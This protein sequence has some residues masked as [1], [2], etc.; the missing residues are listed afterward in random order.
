MYV[1][2]DGQFRDAEHSP[3]VAVNDRDKV[4][5]SKRCHVLSWS[6]R[7]TASTYAAV[8]NVATV[9][10][11]KRH[12]RDSAVLSRIRTHQDGPARL[13][14]LRSDIFATV[15]PV[16]RSAS[17]AATR[18]SRN[19]TSQARVPQVNGTYSGARKFAT[20]RAS[21]SHRC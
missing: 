6:V 7:T 17:A 18:C 12:R 5:R 16:R 9:S 15:M 10:S 8:S 19:G 2:S 4:Y 20:D 11:P 14:G 21:T 3:F 1:D 13:D